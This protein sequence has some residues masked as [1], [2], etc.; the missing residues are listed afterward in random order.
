MGSLRSQNWRLKINLQGLTNAR[1]RSQGG[2]EHIKTGRLNKRRLGQPFRPAENTEP[3][4]V[5]EPVVEKAGEV[6]A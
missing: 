1:R 2:D 6:N 3:E 5:G 4:Q